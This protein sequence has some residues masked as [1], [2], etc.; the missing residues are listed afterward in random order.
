MNNTSKDPRSE[1]CMDRKPLLGNR[2]ASVIAWKIELIQETEEILWPA[3]QNNGS[4]SDE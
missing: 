1:A 2:K 4:C 3:K